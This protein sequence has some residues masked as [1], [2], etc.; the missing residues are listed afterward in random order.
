MVLDVVTLLQ[1]R[2]GR[3]GAV[4]CEMVP[5][6][7]AALLLAGITVHALDICTYYC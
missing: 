5:R 1:Y 4:S 7:V 6:V 2:A 3:D